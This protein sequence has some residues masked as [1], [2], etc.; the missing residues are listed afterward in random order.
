VGPVGDPRSSVARHCHSRPKPRG[1]S[2]PASS[3]R[4]RSA[5]ACSASPVAPS[6]NASG[7]ASSHAAYSA[8]NRRSVATAECHCCGC[9]RGACD[10]GPGARRRSKRARPAVGNR[11]ADMPSRHDIPRVSCRLTQG[12]FLV[13]AEMLHVQVA[14]ALEPVLVH[15]DRQRP[16]QSQSVLGVGEDAHNVGPALDLLVQA[17]E[18]VGCCGHKGPRSPPSLCAL[19]PLARL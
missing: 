9:R 7:S 4:S 3:S 18:H 13:L 11:A 8:W 1:G 5:I 12:L 10:S 16:H 15:L 19:T 6:R 14:G 2:M 17:F